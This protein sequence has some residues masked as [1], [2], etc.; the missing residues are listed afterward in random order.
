[1]EQRIL[2][3]IRLAEQGRAQEAIDVLQA[4][5]TENSQRDKDGWLEWAV[6]SQQASVLAEQGRLADALAKYRILSGMKPP[7]L[8]ES[9][10][11]QVSLFD[12]LDAMGDAEQAI[13][14]L[15]AGLDAA[16]DVAIPTA[17]MALARYAQIAQR[18]SVPVPV[19][20]KALLEEVLNWW[21]INV[22]ED[23]IGDPVSLGAA[24]LYAHDAQRQAAKQFQELEQEAW[25]KK[26]TIEQE[27]ALVDRLRQ[28]AQDS[29]VGFFRQKALEA[30]AALQS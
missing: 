30:L 22:P 1:L 2:D 13:A 29:P 3:V 15:E 10:L 12:T 8:S 9:L 17:L 5:L 26:E 18:E 24:I 27:P 7:N 25:Q 21:G 28:F 14:E 23:L 16:A 11:N 4:L 20:Y 6:L 19:R